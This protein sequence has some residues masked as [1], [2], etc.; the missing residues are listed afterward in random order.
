LYS[1]AFFILRRPR[2][3]NQIRVP[4]VRLIDEAG[5]NVGTVPTNDALRMAMERGLDLIEVAAK[6]SPPVCRIMD[7]GK[8]QYQQE[9]KA[10]Q[11]K[12]K[13]SEVKG[14]R[15]SLAIAKNDLLLKAKQADKFLAQG[16][17]IKIEIILKGREK[18]HANLAKQRLEEF[19][20]MIPMA[21]SIEHGP[22]KYPRGFSMIITKAAEQK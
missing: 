5:Q 15:V 18:A 12:S 22:A 7:F 1:V 3:N 9:K 8:Y 2:I 11:Q 4:E 16:H 19:R 21:T 14:I 10:R 17:K 20:Q 13:R 6:T